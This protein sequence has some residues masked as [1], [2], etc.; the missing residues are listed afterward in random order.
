MRAWD[1]LRPR[2]IA[3]GFTALGLSAAGLIGFAG[4][5]SAH[6]PAE[7]N[8]CSAL[9]VSLTQYNAPKPGRPAVQKPNYLK[10]VINGAT[11]DDEAFG[12]AAS[13]SWINTSG[14]DYTYD[15]SI[16]AWDD[17]TGTK[18]WTKEYKGTQTGCTVGVSPVAPTIQQ[19]SC[20][21]LQPIPGTFT[22]PSDTDTIAY[23]VG[24][25][26]DSN[27]VTATA[28]GK[29][30]LTTPATGGW[31][32]DSSSQTCTVTYDAAPPCA[33]HQPTVSVI[34]TCNSVTYTLGNPA[35]PQSPAASVS[36]VIEK[37]TDG[38]ATYT[39]VDTVVVA[40]GDTATK[41]ESGAAIPAR[42]KR[43][44]NA[45]AKGAVNAT[46]KEGL[47]GSTRASTPCG[48]SGTRVR[49][50]GG[51]PLAFQ[52]LVKPDDQ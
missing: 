35:D 38:G 27:I 36:F 9:T 7:S 11:E 45:R 21:G 4:V 18:G 42:A 17:P 29:G 34:G 10:V 12:S 48:S 31:S 30:E 19:P 22:K 40:P 26:A 52:Y 13:F 51:S 49:G 32:G 20:D 47:R 25:G 50:L 43:V 1:R 41:T 2:R 33:V 44:R 39:T 28:I 46:V 24:I 15:V 5:A 16:T 3:A 6:L 8:S 23:T 14:K 37:S